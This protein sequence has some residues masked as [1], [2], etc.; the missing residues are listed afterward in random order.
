M[1]EAG[2]EWDK[3]L[4]QVPCGYLGRTLSDGASPFKLVYGVSLRMDPRAEIGASIIVPSS[5]SRLRL[6]LPDRYVPR[7]IF[8]GPSEDRRIPVESSHFSQQG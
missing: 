4:N 5:D 8:S 7:A 2:I 6:E 3:A 1:L